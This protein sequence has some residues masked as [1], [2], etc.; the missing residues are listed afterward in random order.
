MS[1]QLMTWAVQQKCGS[2]ATKMVLIMLANHSNGHTQQCTPRHGLLADECEMSKET[3]K[4]HLHKLEE[5][6]LIRIVPRFAD[7]VQLSNQYELLAS[8]QL[9]GGGGKNSPEG[10]VDFWGEGGCKNSPP[11]KQ[12]VKPVNKTS[13]PLHIPDDVS[14]ET[15]KD[16]LQLRKAKKAPVTNTVVNAARR[17][18]DKAGLTLEEFLQIWCARGSQGL[19]ADW[20]KPSEKQIQHNP[21]AGGI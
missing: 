7:G 14:D 5:I 4:S 17:E 1:F 3:L 19:Q 8:Q 9:Q 6:G 15:W 21:F 10:G 20:I 18:A 16:W 11:Y 12:E 2:A 13:V